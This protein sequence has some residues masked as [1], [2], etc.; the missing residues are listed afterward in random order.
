[1]EIMITMV[2]MV[3]NIPRHLTNIP[4]HIM[5]VVEVVAN[6][7]AGMVVVII[8]MKEAGAAVDA[9]LKLVKLPIDAETEAK[10]Q[11]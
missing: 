1:M 9:A 7:A 2:E 3:P 11:N 4:R 6:I 10:P 5:A 8:T